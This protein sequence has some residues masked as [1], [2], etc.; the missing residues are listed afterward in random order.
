METHDLVG[1]NSPPI[2]TRD[3]CAQLMEGCVPE[4]ATGGRKLR[5]QK[6]EAHTK[7]CEET[8][9]K[10][11]GWKVTVVYGDRGAGM[12]DKENG[13]EILKEVSTIQIIRFVK[14]YDCVFKQAVEFPD[15]QNLEIQ[16]SKKQS[17]VSSS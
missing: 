8:A 11:R 13:A 17:V 9:V 16:K 3:N 2:G 5:L 15:L 4:A 6:Q 14:Y 10:A 7:G 12:W 1:Y